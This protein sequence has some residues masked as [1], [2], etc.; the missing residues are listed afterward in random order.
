MENINLEFKKFVSDVKSSGF[1]EKIEE[2]KHS[3]LLSTG[4]HC[5]VNFCEHIK[6]DEDCVDIIIEANRG[7]KC[8]RNYFDGIELSLLDTDAVSK[9][10]LFIEKTLLKFIF[11]TENNLN[12]SRV[13]KRI[14]KNHQ[15]YHQEQY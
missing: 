6:Y 1:N 5:V 9:A 14:L 12:Q 8:E 2:M 4:Y 13:I 10:R 7:D 11:Y 3:F 15:K